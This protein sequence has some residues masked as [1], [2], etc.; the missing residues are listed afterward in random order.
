M[1]G[2]WNEINE[3]VEQSQKVHTVKWMKQTINVW[4]REMLRANSSKILSE[5]FICLFVSAA[6]RYNNNNVY[7][8]SNAPSE[9]RRST[10]HTN[11]Q[12]KYIERE[13]ERDWW[14]PNMFQ[15]QLSLSILVGVCLCTSANHFCLHAFS[16]FQLS[17]DTKINI[18]KKVGIHF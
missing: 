5:R 16:V 14:L 1:L 13:R 7:A 2:L 4:D 11:T 3:N 18:C 15:H 9:T 8:D 6:V 17:R 12:P 10:P